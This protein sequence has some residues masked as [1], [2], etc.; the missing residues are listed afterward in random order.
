MPEQDDLC[1]PFLT[2][3][4]ELQEAQVRR[5]IA[6]I[7][8]L[9]WGGQFGGGIC[10]SCGSTRPHGHAEGCVIALALK[11]DCGIADLHGALAEGMRR[12]ASRRRSL[13][14]LA[15][16]AA[17]ELEDLGDCL[18]WVQEMLGRLEQSR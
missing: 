1:P 16:A 2:R 8:E 7:R 5:L 18:A 17:Q 12:V 10:P 15:G 14:S 3:H 4:S 11:P 13:Q 6:A 9:E